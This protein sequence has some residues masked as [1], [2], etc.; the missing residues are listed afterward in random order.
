MLCLSLVE[1]SLSKTATLPLPPRAIVFALFKRLTAI[2]LSMCFS[3]VGTC[4]R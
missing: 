2:K 4:D 1:S 3:T